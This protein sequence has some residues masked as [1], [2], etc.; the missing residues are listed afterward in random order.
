[1]ELVT[2]QISTT[3]RQM[4]TGDFLELNVWQRSK[5]FAVDIYRITERG[6]F[7]KDQNLKVRVRSTAVSIA[8]RIAE[9]DEMGAG[10][11]AVRLFNSARGSIAN[12]VTQL[13]IAYEIGYLTGHCFDQIRE[14][15]QAI[16]GM[17]A[18]LINARVRAA[19]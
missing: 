11:G 7:K 5:D 4:V 2:H 8:S 19:H 3:Q 9:A 10:A 16:S 12:L 1:M 17:L 14:E 13:A 18:R 15:C 6:P